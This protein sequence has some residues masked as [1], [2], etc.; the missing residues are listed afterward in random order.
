MRLLLG[1]EPHRLE[2]VHPV[3]I[4]ELLSLAADRNTVAV[5]TI[6]EMLAS[7]HAEGRSSPYLVKLSHSP[8]W[9][10]KPM[11]CG[12][13]RGGSRVYLFLLATGEAGIVNCEVKKPD[14]SAGQSMLAVGL[15]M[16]K[17]Y[18]E[19]TPVFEAAR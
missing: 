14:A 15:R 16:L 3:I 17:A 2:A 1:R 12:G 10:L 7:L 18:N 9:E 19:G 8:L 13:E 11:S 6:V 5:T 4:D